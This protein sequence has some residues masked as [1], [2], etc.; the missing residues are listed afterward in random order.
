M[1]MQQPAEMTFLDLIKIL[2]QYKWVMLIVFISVQVGAVVYSYTATN[3]YSAEVIVASADSGGSGGGLSSIMAAMGG[4]GG[5]GSMVGRRASVSQG[6]ATLESEQFIRKFIEEN[7]LLPI[8]YAN[9]WDSETSDWKASTSD[10]KPRLSDGYRKFSNTL[11]IDDPESGLYTLKIRWTDPDVAANWANTLIFRLNERLRSTAIQEAN[12][13]IDFLKKEVEKTRIVELQQAIY[14]MI[15]EQ[16]NIRT[17]ANIRQEY[18]FKVIG[19]AIAPEL[20]QFVSP[21]RPLI[22]ILAIC[23]GLILGMFAGWFVYAI[24]YLRTELNN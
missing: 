7:N 11:T 23:A 10:N 19:P 21:R 22:F 14:F 15:E 20:D 9:R 5:L 1:N 17:M 8:L 18:A 2:V 13:T 16:I 4:G 12:Q 6:M 3:V 24:Q